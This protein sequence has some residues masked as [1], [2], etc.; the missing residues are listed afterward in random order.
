M[1]ELQLAGQNLGRVIN[2]RSGCRYAKHLFCNEAE[3]PN[4]KLKTR[5]KQFLGSLS[6]AFALP[7]SGRIFMLNQQ[8]NTNMAEPTHLASRTSEFQVPPNT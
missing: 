4:L 7:V 2:S 5:P 1:D 8:P 6:I 3:H